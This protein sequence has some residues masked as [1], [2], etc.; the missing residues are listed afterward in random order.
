MATTVLGDDGVAMVR[1]GGQRGDGKRAVTMTGVQLT[2][3]VAHAN[4]HVVQVDRRVAVAGHELH[5]GAHG[6]V[7]LVHTMEHAVL[8]AAVLGTWL[9]SSAGDDVLFG[10]APVNVSVAAARIVSAFAA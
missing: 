5:G 9:V 10:D 1:R 6:Q 4:E 7:V 3:G 8:V 2:I